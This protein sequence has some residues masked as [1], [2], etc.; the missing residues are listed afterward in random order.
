LARFLWRKIF[1]KIRSILID[2]ALG[3]GLAALIIEG[4]IVKRAIET[5]MKETA[6]SGALLTKGNSLRKLYLPSA[7]IAVHQFA[8][9][10]GL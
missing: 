4:G 1:A 3:L 7:V 5:N 6:A 2:Y 8:P 9:A 10:S